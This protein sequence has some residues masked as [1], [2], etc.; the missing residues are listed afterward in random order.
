LAT[1]LGYLE[2]SH[3]VI[4]VRKRLGENNLIVVNSGISKLC[5]N[6]LVISFSFRL[7]YPYKVYKLWRGIILRSP[8]ISP[9]FAIPPITIKQKFTR[10]KEHYSFFGVNQIDDIKRLWITI[11]DDYYR[12]MYIEH[13]MYNRKKYRYHK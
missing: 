2:A 1:L 7:P 11:D 6:L 10:W 13:S 8:R 9:A 4:F 3:A 5:S 12:Y